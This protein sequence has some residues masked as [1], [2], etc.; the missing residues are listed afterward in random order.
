MTLPA[1]P[2]TFDQV[3]PA[4]QFRTRSGQFDDRAILQIEHFPDGVFDIRRDDSGTAQKTRGYPG[5]HENRFQFFH[6]KAPC[7]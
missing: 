6:C 2:R 3:L 4:L 7:D 1:V 5:G